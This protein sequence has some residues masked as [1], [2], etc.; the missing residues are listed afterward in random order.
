M[1]RGERAG[2]HGHMGFL[3]ELW[4]TRREGSLGKRTRLGESTRGKSMRRRGQLGKVQLRVAT[5]YERAS[6]GTYSG[7]GGEEAARGSKAVQLNCIAEGYSHGP[8]RK[9]KM[10]YT[11]SKKKGGHPD[12]SGKP[13]I[14]GYQ[15]IGREEK[16][17][18]KDK[19]QI[20]RPTKITKIKKKPY[21][22]FSESLSRML[23]SGFSPFT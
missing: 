2:P 7:S 5:L 23:V 9:R 3:V 22:V 8:Q 4:Q 19:V 10:T 1:Y 18:E 6:V 20:F 21:L 12:D 11:L 17:N 14:G 16:L 13:S 15:S